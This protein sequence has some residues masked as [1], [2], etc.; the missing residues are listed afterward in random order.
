M[1]RHQFPSLPLWRLFCNG[2][3]IESSNLGESGLTRRE[4]QTEV[5]R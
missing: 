4:R 3:N 2:N 5:C 1:C